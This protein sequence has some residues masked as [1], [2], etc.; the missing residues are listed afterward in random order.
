MSIAARLDRYWFA[1]ARLRDLAYMRIAIVLVLLLGILWPGA[2][3]EQ[4]LRTSL[5]AEW[6][7]PLPALKL[8]ML[9][10]G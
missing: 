10:F 2:L 3:D 4:L 1:P 9:P 5:P 7:E 8:L 6:F